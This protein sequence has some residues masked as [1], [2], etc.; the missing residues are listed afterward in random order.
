MVKQSYTLYFLVTFSFIFTAFFTTFLFVCTVF[1]KCFLLAAG[2]IN[3]GVK[4]VSA[5]LFIIIV[6]DTCSVLIVQATSLKTE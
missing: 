5:T 6:V 2:Y 4:F 3:S 1:A